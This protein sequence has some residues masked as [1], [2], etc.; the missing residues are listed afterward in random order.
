MRM[1]E[2]TMNLTTHGVGGTAEQVAPPQSN[3]AGSKPPLPESA[4]LPTDQGT[5]TLEL[6]E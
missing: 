2:L 3:V 1:K 4:T 5:L 6:I